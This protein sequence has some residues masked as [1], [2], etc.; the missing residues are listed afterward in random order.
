V[1]GAARVQFFPLLKRQEGD[2]FMVGRPE[3]NSFIYLP[4]EGVALIEFLEQGMTLEETQTAYNE[5]Y[6]EVPDVAD[7][8]DGLNQV[9]FV[10]R[11][12]GSGEEIPVDPSPE[13]APAQPPAPGGHFA[14]I[15]P[16]TAARFFSRPLLWIYG[17]YI[18]GAL[19]VLA[20]RPH[21]FPS[22]ADQFFLGVSL[23]VSI[24]SLTFYGWIHMFIHEF[25]HLLAARSV[26]VPA[27]LSLGR[28]LMTP[29]ALT[30]MSAIY[31]A[32]PEQ[33]YLPYLAGMLFDLIAMATFTYLLALS[34][35]GV[36]LI[37]A[38]AYGFLKAI[39]ARISIAFSFQ[40]RLPL[41]TDLYYVVAN[42][43]RA[44]NLQTDT[45]G[46]LGNLRDRL[47]RRKPRYDLSGVP[48]REM[49]MI[50]T[51][52]PIL[53]AGLG[54]YWVFFVYFT[55]P[56][57]AKTFPVAFRAVAA[58]PAK[59]PLSFADGAIFLVM[60]AVEWGWLLYVTIRDWRAG[61]RQQAVAGGR[62][63]ERATA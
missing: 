54:L 3:I 55:V 17:A 60:M 22:G 2:E 10:M 52:A 37:P 26:G 4:P 53:L 25:A 33:R 56:F 32:A 34:D 24:L 8:V 1:D 5:R 20:L 27:H 28:R 29:V 38:V 58:G 47:L 23:V 6:G 13:A 61:R 46:F 51:Y 15:A 59:S 44:R 35:W 9:G 7:L 18:L 14:W 50:R 48:A 36:I 63:D 43:L 57:L 30:D 21:L 62:V 12:L 49:W 41:R 19:V 39:L 31:A 45:L 16:R 11:I 42:W 40:F